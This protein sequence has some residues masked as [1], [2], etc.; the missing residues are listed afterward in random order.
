M[1]S[2]KEYNTFRDKA[3]K[4]Y[5][6]FIRASW[7]FYE[8]SPAM[9][10]PNEEPIPPVIYKEEQ[11]EREDENILIDNPITI[12]LPEPQ[13]KPIEP[14]KPQ[15]QPIKSFCQFSFFNTYC[16]V[17]IPRNLIN[18][19]SIDNEELANAWET[20]SN[21]EFDATLYDCLQLRDKMQ[22]CDWAYLLLLKEL[23][24]SA[25]KALNN[26]SVLLTAWLYCQSGYQMR[27]ANDGNKLHMLYASQ[28]TI[29]NQSY[30][31]LDGFNYYSLLPISDKLQ[32]CSAAFE[33]EQA[34][35]LQ[36]SIYPTL[37]ETTSQTRNLQSERY[38]NLKVSVRVN[39][40][41]ID[42]YDT[43]PSS[44]LNSNPLTRWAMYA[45]TPLTDNVKR[46]LYPTLKHQIQNL[47]NRQ[48]IE[49][50]LNFV[51]TAFVYEYDDKVWGGDRALFAEETL[52]YPYADCEDRSILFSRLVR[53][54]LNLPVVLVY[55]PGH[56]AT[57]VAFQ[58]AEQGDYIMLDGKR[59][60]ICDPTYIGAPVG[61][62]MPKMENKT[63]KVILL[64]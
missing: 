14:I 36:V 25:Y 22:L 46:D 56:L 17:S 29:Y 51:Q 3:N 62:T 30:Y 41:L 19:G 47:S 33:N 21:G 57:A 42:F 18:L 59:F 15:P 60:T 34:L 40:N 7:E 24:I 35:S 31:Q 12:P 11:E 28:Y 8:A 38:K 26:E 37:K 50:L 5:A 6:D 27:L 49:Q 61:A 43:Y 55:Y 2:E 4:D 20:L 44:E 9:S 45:N 52:Y 39:K 23:S 10:K 54:L 48:A 53:D 64:E 63:A 58:T 1:D 16:E 32:I 13:P